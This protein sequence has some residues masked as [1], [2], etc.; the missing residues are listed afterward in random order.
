MRHSRSKSSDALGLIESKRRRL[1][2]TVVSIYCARDAELDPDGGAYVT[3]CE[4]H[5]SLC[6]SADYRGEVSP[7]GRRMT[8]THAVSW[9]SLS[10]FAPVLGWRRAHELAVLKL[11]QVDGLQVNIPLVVD[12]VAQEPLRLRHC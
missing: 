9:S 1:T 10:L 12:R 7:E 5:G 3:V 11:D 6:K 8:G 2:K 4:D